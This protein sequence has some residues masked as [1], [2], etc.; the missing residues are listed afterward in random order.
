MTPSVKGLALIKLSL[1]EIFYLLYRMIRYGLLGKEFNDQHGHVGGAI[2]GGLVGLRKPIN[3]GVPYSLAEEF[4]GVYRM[5]SLLPDYP[6]LRD[7]SATPGPNK[8]PPLL[9]EC[10]LYA[11]RLIYTRKNFLSL[12]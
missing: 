6:Q 3:Y 4:V 8:Q 5:R 2:L 12:N 1:E 10:I 7:I 9:E 11:S